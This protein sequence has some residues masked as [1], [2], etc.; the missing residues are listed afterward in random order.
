MTAQQAMQDFV[1]INKEMG[2]S[3]LRN[4]HHVELALEYASRIIGILKPKVEHY[5]YDYYA[6]VEYVIDATRPT[7]R[8]VISLTFRREPVADDRVFSLCLSSYRSSGAGGYPWYT[9]CPVLREINTEITDL[10][11]EFF[12][13]HPQGPTLEADNYRVVYPGKG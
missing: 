11:L 1:R 6:G 7:G 4:I 3:I 13:N 8:R 10:I 9:G 5:N 2:I 12:G